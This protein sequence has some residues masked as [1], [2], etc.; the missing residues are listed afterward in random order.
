MAPLLMPNLYALAAIV[1][2]ASLATLGVSLS[3]VPPFLLTGIALMVGSTL[4]WP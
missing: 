2:W 3:H 1:L 4:A